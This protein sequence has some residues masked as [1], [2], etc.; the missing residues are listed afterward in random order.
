MF[1]SLLVLYTGIG[2]LLASAARPSPW[3]TYA[4]DFVAEPPLPR[5]SHP[6]KFENN[7]IL[8]FSDHFSDLDPT[9]WR[10]RYFSNLDHFEFGGAIF[11][12]IGGPWE[13][14]P[15]FVCGG[16]VVD[17]AKNT[18]GAVFYLEHRFY[19][20]SHPAKLAVLKGIQY[21]A[22]LCN[23]SLFSQTKN[24]ERTVPVDQIAD[25][26]RYSV[27]HRTP[28]GTFVGHGRIPSD[29]LWI[30]FRRKSSRLDTG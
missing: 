1:V 26:R 17:A 25:N 7:W 15:H 12:I 2:L 6:T 5:C 8:Q 18:N 20:Q 28:E 30:A 29:P 27:L 10:L 13:I 21:I 4:V 23:L 14:S 19:G 3:N 9:V 16:L 24:Q 22:V 11:V